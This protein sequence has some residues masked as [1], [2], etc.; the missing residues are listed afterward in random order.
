MWTHLSIH[1]T[2]AGSAASGFR[3]YRRL[4]APTSATGADATSDTEV[5]R[6]PAA[7]RRYKPSA[8]AA[9]STGVGTSM[10]SLVRSPGPP[11]GNSPALRGPLAAATGSG[12]G[13]RRPPRA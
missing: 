9:V 11:P 8:P 4:H 13:P 1:L 10:G 6:Y 2:N 3:T 12:R 7:I 5:R